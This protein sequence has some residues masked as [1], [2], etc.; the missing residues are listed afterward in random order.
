MPLWISLKRR[1]RNIKLGWRIS[2]RERKQKREELKGL[3]T[4]MVITILPLLISQNVGLKSQNKK[5]TTWI[6]ISHR[7]TWASEINGF[8]LIIHLICIPQCMILISEQT[9][10]HLKNK[11]KM[12]ER[13]LIILLCHQPG[14]IHPSHHHLCRRLKTL[15]PPNNQALTETAT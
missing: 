9:D 5:R 2:L 4:I 8:H 6:K 11:R 13:I 1:I 14:H 7:E 12:M 3:E 15:Q 10:T